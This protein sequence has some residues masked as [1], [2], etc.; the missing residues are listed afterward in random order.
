M[1]LPK[2]R[3]LQQNQAAA[4]DLQIK[5]RPD[6]FDPTFE[7]ARQIAGQTAQCFAV[8]ALLVGFAEGRICYSASGIPLL[9]ASKGP[10]FETS[11]EATSFGTT[12]P[13]ADF[14]LPVTPTKLG[15]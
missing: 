12:V 4:F 5:E 6:Q 8:K 1:G 14:K 3:A 9:I 13:D 7:G 15:G 10:G 11:K 2:D